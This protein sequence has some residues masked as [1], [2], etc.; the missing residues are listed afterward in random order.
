LT[1]LRRRRCC[2]AALPPLQ[3]FGELD[4]VQEGRNAV[5]FKELY[6]NIPGIYVP[7][8]DFDLTTR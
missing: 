8:I 2:A 5:R 4:Y 6:G 1:P 3:L 7:D